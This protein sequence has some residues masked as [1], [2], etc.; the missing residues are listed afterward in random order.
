MRTK[1]SLKALDK[2]DNTLCLNANR[3][4]LEFNIDKDEHIDCKDVDEMVD[5]IEIIKKDLMKKPKYKK[6]DVLFKDIRDL[7]DYDVWEA[8]YLVGDKN[9][10]R[11]CEVFGYHT[12]FRNKKVCDFLDNSFE[13]KVLMDAQVLALGNNYCILDVE[14]PCMEGE[15]EDFEY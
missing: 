3:Q 8:G 2:L 5:C 11:I 4:N 15:Y 12:T 13:N 9:G 6:R 14:L 10:H 7:L 1:K